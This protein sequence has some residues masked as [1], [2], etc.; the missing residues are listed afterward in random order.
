MSPYQRCGEIV[1]LGKWQTKAFAFQCIY[2]RDEEQ[3][4]TL[5]DF[6]SHLES[7]HADLFEDQKVAQTATDTTLRSGASKELAVE[8]DLA[9]VKGESVEY[10]REQE[11]PFDN[12][13]S[14]SDAAAAADPL[15]EADDA[16]VECFEPETMLDWPSQSDSQS[17]TSQESYN[18]LQP[19]GT[20]TCTDTSYFWL[21]EHPIMLAFI[22]QLEEQ[23]LLWDLGML[24]YRNYKRRSAACSTIAER[25][26]SQ[27]GLQLT[28]EEVAGHTKRLQNVYRRERQR[29][30]RAIAQGS[31]TTTAP[32]WYYE[33]LGFLAK[34]LRRKRHP[35]MSVS[36]P[37]PHLNHQQCL[38][39]IEIYQQCSGTWDMQD[40]SCRLR[41]VRDAAKEKLLSLCRAELQMPQLEPSLLQRYTRNLRN[42][43][44]QEKLRRIQC[45]R[46]GSGGGGGG[47]GVVFTPR[48]RYYEQLRFLEPHVA[49]F[50]CDLCEQLL[51]SVDVYKVHRA[52][53][54]G[55][56]PFV[57]PTCGR[58]FSRSGNCTI[59]LRRHTHDYQLGCEECGK[60]FAT[61]SDLQ[62]HRRSHTGERPFCC[63][64]CGKRFSTRSFFERHRRRHEQRP[65]GK[66]SICG[67]SF[68]EQSVLNDHI[69]GH[70]NVRDKECD[71]CHKTFTS[72][73]YL[74][75]H[76]EIHNPQKRYICKICAKGFAQYAGLSGHMKSH[77]RTVPPDPKMMLENTSNGCIERQLDPSPLQAINVD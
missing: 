9:I 50:Q 58:G 13:L 32:H 73:K 59:H 30:E 29:L 42:A 18:E 37:V 62:V 47:G 5:K 66:C 64:I 48:C 33:R 40:L 45:E 14:L 2:C 72:C 24:A 56:L 36:V 25:L 1:W 63:D 43:Y 27:F 22:G 68:F 65:R 17:T 55:S 4:R 46:K 28:G 12:A 57:C 8:E 23:S 53:H 52:G 71:I 67:K 69:K 51:N 44:Q 16:S 15:S 6:K 20:G 19:T 3:T 10:A 41:H 39:L 74:R 26:N 34:S 35:K 77:G 75:Q 38:K 61:T 7:K 70:L 31:T 60:R 11:P 54:D 76:K 49:P 21:Q